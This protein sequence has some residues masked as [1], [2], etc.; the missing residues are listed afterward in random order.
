MTNARNPLI[1]IREWKSAPHIVFSLLLIAK[2]PQKLDWLILKSGCSGKTT[3]QAI[4]YLEDIHCIINTKTGW[5]IKIGR[6]H[7]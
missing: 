2:K 3:V 1:T 5:A 6:A 7:V 4:R